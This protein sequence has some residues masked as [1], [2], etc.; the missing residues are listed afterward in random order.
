MVK[1]RRQ[2]LPDG[3]PDNATTRTAD[4]LHSSALRLLRRARAADGEM[5][6]DGPPC[7]GSCPCS[8][9]AVRYR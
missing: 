1:N 7:V 6:L 5:D 8:P 3:V 4:A 9:S 2:E